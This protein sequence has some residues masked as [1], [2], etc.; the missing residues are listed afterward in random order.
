MVFKEGTAK[1]GKPCGEH[2]DCDMLREFLRREDISRQHTLKLEVHI[3]NLMHNLHQAGIGNQSGRLTMNN[4]QAKLDELQ[5]AYTASEATR[6]RVESEL[7]EERLEHRG[8][9]E[10]LTHE[11]NSHADTQKTLECFWET[12]KKLG[13]FCD[14]VTGLLNGKPANEEMEKQTN[15][16]DLTLEIEYRKQTMVDMKKDEELKEEKWTIDLAA[17]EQKLQDQ[18]AEHEDSARANG[19]RVAELEQ[20]LSELQGKDEQYVDLNG[21][22]WQD[23]RRKR[24]TRRSIIRH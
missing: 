5:T 4:L 12:L 21:L 15:V 23:T 9:R 1:S 11:I 6:A 19:L 10:S 17:L 13:N 3:A 2:L 20:M 8:T 7:Q 14:Y 24:R 22:P 18:A 16:A